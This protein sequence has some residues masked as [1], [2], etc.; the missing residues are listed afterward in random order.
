MAEFLGEGALVVIIRLPA[1]D[2]TSGGSP[3][4]DGVEYLSR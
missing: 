2:G 1:C 4:D 3:V